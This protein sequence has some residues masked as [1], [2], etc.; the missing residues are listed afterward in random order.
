ML[1]SNRSAHCCSPTE[2]EE[3]QAMRIAIFETVSVRDVVTAPLEQGQPRV[4]VHAGIDDRHLLAGTSGEPPGIA[5]VEHGFSAGLQPKIGLREHTSDTARRLTLGRF[6]RSD[7]TGWW[8]SRRH[9]RRWHRRCRR[10]GE[11]R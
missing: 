4:S 7:R 3:T 8:R 11:S 9:D 10:H 5:D 2:I 6:G 1:W